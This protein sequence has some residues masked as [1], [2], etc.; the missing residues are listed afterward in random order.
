ML[1]SLFPSVD[2]PVFVCRFDVIAQ[3]PRVEPEPVIVR[4][5]LLLDGRCGELADDVAVCFLGYLDLPVLGLD[6]EASL[7][8]V[9]LQMGL[10]RIAFIFGEEPLHCAV[11]SFLC[12]G[13]LRLSR[14]LG[15]LFGRVCRVSLIQC[16]GFDKSE[17]KN[18]P[19]SL[20]AWLPL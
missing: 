5:A 1:D 11:V 13:E 3:V 20:D 2:D 19:G 18:S 17:Y 4:F 16:C 12:V 15:W 7:L 6:V 9:R 14:G 10:A 8:D